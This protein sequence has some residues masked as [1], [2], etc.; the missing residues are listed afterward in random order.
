MWDDRSILKDRAPIP[1]LVTMARSQV[2]SRSHHD[3]AHLHPLTNVPTKYQIPTPYGSGD[4]AQPSP[5][6]LKFTMARSKV[7]SRSHHDVAHL[8]PPINV[9]TKYQH[10]T[11]Y[12][13]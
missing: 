13:F 6:K 7:K 5:P 12:G 4:I 2:K 8:H 11:P 1:T 3:V 9:P 10:P